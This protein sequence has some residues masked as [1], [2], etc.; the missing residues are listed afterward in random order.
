MGILRLVA[1]LCAPDEVEP[2][3]SAGADELYCGIVEDW[4]R[5]RYGEHDSANRRQ[6]VASL[7]K[8]TELAQVL[9][10]AE[11][12]QVPVYLTVNVRYTEPQLD[13]LTELCLDF[14]KMGGTGIIISDIGLLGRLNGITGLR[15][16]LSLLAVADNIPTITTY[17][18]LGITRLVFPR[19]VTPN[20]ANLLLEPFAGVEAEVMAFFDKCPFVDG[21]CR[22]YHGVARADWQGS[23]NSVS[24]EPLHTFDTTFKTHAC[25]GSEQRYLQADPC[26]ACHLARYETAGVGFA[27]I[28]GRGRPLSDR[29]MALRF[30]RAAL[31]LADDA[32]RAELYQQTFAH[33]CQCYYGEATQ[34]RAAIE[35][36]RPVIGEKVYWIDY[37]ETASVIECERLIVGSNTDP[38]TLDKLLSSWDWLRSL[39]APLTIVIPP[40]S[41]TRIADLI[42]MLERLCSD[43]DEETHLCVNDLGSFRCAFDFGKLRE[44]AS[45]EAGCDCAAIPFTIT[46]GS[47]LARC[48]DLATI[49]HF[50]DPAENPERLVH[51]ADDEPRL[52]TYTPP[53]PEL[54]RH[55][56]SPSAL[57]H[58]A[59]TTLEKLF[60][61]QQ[62]IYEFS[63]IIER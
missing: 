1:P 59:Q 8:R 37:G 4:W 6:G 60:D 18:D 5:S 45:H 20:D 13:Y 50:L 21:Y 17:L 57:E 9:T 36:R 51:G 14:E 15:R 55:W 47:L 27:K 22:H 31:A 43:C 61:G 56:Q 49:A 3:V 32:R 28:G 16:C 26:A 62:I 41:Q 48:D 30:L 10:R 12:L 44:I 25:L 2:L 34:S 19:F 38:A 23:L 52:L 39:P 58:T 42:S 40:L 11:K 54:I 24:V 53:S 63:E 29:L 7:S 46:I 33:S 35:P